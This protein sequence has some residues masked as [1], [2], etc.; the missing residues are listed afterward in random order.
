MKKMNQKNQLALNKETLADL[1]GITGGVQRNGQADSTIV[2]VT[3]VTTTT[4]TTVTTMTITKG[5]QR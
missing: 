3:T 4:V 2:T 1:S 5:E